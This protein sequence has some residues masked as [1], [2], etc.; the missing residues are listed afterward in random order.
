MS[1]SDNRTPNTGLAVNEQK[2]IINWVT[3]LESI[4]RSITASTGIDG[5]IVISDTDTHYPDEGKTFF[6]FEA[7]EDTAEINSANGNMDGIAGLTLAQ[8][9][10][11]FGIF[12][13]IKLTSGKI[14]AYM[15]EL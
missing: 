10:K 14:I 2:E 9:G 4:V 1:L 5:S 8:H 13:D 15:K 6:C 3:K 12:Q 7:V 11:A